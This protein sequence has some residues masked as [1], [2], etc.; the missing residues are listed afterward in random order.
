M[1]IFEMSAFVDEL[2]LT[3]YCAGHEN[4]GQDK[5]NT[6]QMTFQTDFKLIIEYIFLIPFENQ[7]S[8]YYK[9]G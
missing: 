5:K 9:G 7:K 6:M 1:D 4:P 3:K 8:A 2:T